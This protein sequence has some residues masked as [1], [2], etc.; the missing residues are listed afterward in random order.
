MTIKEEL[1]LLKDQINGAYENIEYLQTKCKHPKEFVVKDPET[2]A[3]DWDAP[4]KGVHY[5]YNCKCTQCDK[6]WKESQ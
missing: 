2:D 6:R 5:W 1:D 4:G 3:D